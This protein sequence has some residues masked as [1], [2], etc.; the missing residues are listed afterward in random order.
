M[1]QDANPSPARV[2]AVMAPADAQ[3][4]VTPE[5]LALINRY[6]LV[7]LQAEEIYARRALVATDAVTRTD[8]RLPEPYLARLAETLPGKSLMLH[9]DTQRVLVGLV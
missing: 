2:R 4:A 8:E 6:A 3:P 1:P 9:H 5:A 7:P